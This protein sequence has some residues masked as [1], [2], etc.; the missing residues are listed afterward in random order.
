MKIAPKHDVMHAPKSLVA[1]RTA[2]STR[3][4]FIWAS[5][6]TSHEVDYNFLYKI[7]DRSIAPG[8]VK[9]D[10]QVRRAQDER[11][12]ASASSLAYFSKF[13]VHCVLSNFI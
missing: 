1:M 6:V 5:D 4:V 3:D 8:Q 7:A 10:S 2:E 12:F 11:K 9:V 13:L